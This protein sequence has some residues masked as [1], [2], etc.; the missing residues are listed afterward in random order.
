[1]AIQQ[2]QISMNNEPRPAFFNRLAGKML[3]LLV[4]AICTGTARA[5]DYV[6]K[7]YTDH[8]SIFQGT[9]GI[10]IYGNDIKDNL[11][12]YFLKSSTPYDASLRHYVDSLNVAVYSQSHIYSGNNTYEGSTVFTPC[13]TCQIIFNGGTVNF[14]NGLNATNLYLNGNLSMTSEGITA[15]LATGGGNLGFA[16][17]THLNGIRI[18]A[19]QLYDTH[20]VP[21]LKS[22]A[23]TGGT[24][25][26]IAGAETLTNKTLTTPKLTG[27]TVATLPAGTTG[28][29]AYVT[30]ATAPTYLGTLTGGGSVVTP[31]FYNGAAWV[32]H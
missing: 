7:N 24:L 29:E 14:P 8:F 2:P 16:D 5:Q 11:G 3:L 26:S 17:Y 27:Y 31:V 22:T 15:V 32:A 10:N 4:L 6:F 19:D 23:I 1:M 21:Y 30:D 25:A 20:N 18:T 9:Q 13:G 28:M 12:N